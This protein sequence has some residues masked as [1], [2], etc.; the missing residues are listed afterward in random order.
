MKP[1]LEFESGSNDPMA[2]LLTITLIQ[3]IETQ[4][5]NMWY[6]V[7][8]F[9]FQFIFGTL[10]GFGLGKLFIWILNKL[11][12]HNRS[13]YPVLLI[14]VCF[15][16]FTLTN[17]LQGNGYLAVY[18]GGLVIGNSKF[19]QKFS[20]KRFFDGLTWLFQIIM[21]L[22]LGLLVNPR[23]LLPVTGIGLIIG[24]FMILFGR[25]LRLAY[26]L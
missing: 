9:L 26:Y 21:F 19:T 12:L 23:E 16:I 1:L 22:C 7:G 15:F 25:P 5:G 18:I 13:L 4:T 24:L 11:E 8:F 3:V 17:D 14:A 2:Y 10:M 6:I 20:S